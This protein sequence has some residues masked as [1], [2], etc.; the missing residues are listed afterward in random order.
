VSARAEDLLH[1]SFCDKSAEQVAKL[2]AGPG[3]YICDECVGLCNEIIVDSSAT[4]L[5][6]LTEM[7]SQVDHMVDKLRHDGVSWD[8]IS[9]ALRKDTDE[10]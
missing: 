5:E 4:S 10:D 8:D 1:C 2:I 9:K 3:V 7:S 6:L